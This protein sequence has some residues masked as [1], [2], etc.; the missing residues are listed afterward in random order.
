MGTRSHNDAAMAIGFATYHLARC[1]ACSKPTIWHIDGNT[2]MKEWTLVY[3]QGSVAPPR[4][5]GMPTP[6]AEVYDEASQVAVASPRAATAL[7]RLAVELL[8][9]ELGAEG[10]DL[11]QKVRWL[12]KQGASDNIQKAMDSVRV[13]GNNAVHALQIIADEPSA[14][15]DLLFRLNNYL[16]ETLI[17]GK[18]EIQQFYDKLPEAVRKGIEQRDK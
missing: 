4:A 11:N 10:K 18:A 2:G 12:V 16:V 6:V 1:Q 9:K 3:P 8:L 17:T 14:V 7:L 13:S 5:T 15:A